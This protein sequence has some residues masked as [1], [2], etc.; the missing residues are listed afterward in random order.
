MAILWSIDGATSKAYPTSLGHLSTL[1]EHQKL[2]IGSTVVPSTLIGTCSRRGSDPST[3]NTL[4]SLVHQAPVGGGAHFFI[5]PPAR[6]HPMP[7]IGQCWPS[8]DTCCIALSRVSNV[9]NRWVSCKRASSLVARVSILVIGAYL[10]VY[11]MVPLTRSQ[12]S[13]S[14]GGAG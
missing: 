5:D 6:L 1:T 3:V 2:G 4:P 9:V 11:G 10:L 12:Y 7:S 13:L 14:G 8:M